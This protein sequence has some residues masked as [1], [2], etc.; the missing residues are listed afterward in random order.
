MEISIFDGTGTI[1]TKF[2]KAHEC[3]TG[4]MIRVIYL[5]NKNMPLRPI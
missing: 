5:C 2:D 4:D 3:K 1:K